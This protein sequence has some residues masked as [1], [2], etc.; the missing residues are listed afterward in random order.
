MHVDDEKEMMWL[1]AIVA[2]F[3]VLTQNSLKLLS[4]KSG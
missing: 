2:Y 1:E 3:K 4:R